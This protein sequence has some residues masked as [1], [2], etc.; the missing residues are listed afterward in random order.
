MMADEADN[1]IPVRLRD[2][3]ATPD[4]H[5]RHFDKIEMRPT[6]TEMQCDDG[7]KIVRYSP[8]QSAQMQLRQRRQESGNDEHLKKLERLLLDKCQCEVDDP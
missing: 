1:I 8:G 6:D 7:N 2:I 3:R 5:S 4:A